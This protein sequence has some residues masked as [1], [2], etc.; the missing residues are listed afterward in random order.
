MEDFQYEPGANILRTEVQDLMMTPI[1]DNIW[2]QCGKAT[3]AV[4]PLLSN[5]LPHSALCKPANSWYF[6]GIGIDVP[7]P[8]CSWNVGKVKEG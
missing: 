4:V 1:K 5:V 6:V 2:V 3:P 7:S 8:Q